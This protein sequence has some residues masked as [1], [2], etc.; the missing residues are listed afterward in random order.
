MVGAGG[1]IRPTTNCLARVGAGPKLGTP[2]PTGGAVCG[3]GGGWSFG[4]SL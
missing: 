3:G 1:L 4:L 2:L